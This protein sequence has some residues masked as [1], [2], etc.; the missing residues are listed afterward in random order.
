MASESAPFQSLESAEASSD[1]LVF[2]QPREQRPSVLEAFTFL[3]KAERWLLILVIGG[4]C[5]LLS[6]MVPIVP[7]MFFSGYIM[8]LI[9]Q[10]IRRPNATV[11]F[12]N[13][14]DV[15]AY[16]ERGAWTVLAQIVLGILISIPMTICLIGLIIITLAVGESGITQD[17]SAQMLLLTIFIFAFGCLLL[18]SLVAYMFAGILWFRSGMAGSFKEAFQFKWALS[19]IKTCGL[20]IFFGFFCLA[21]IG[22]LLNL[23]GLLMFLVGTYFMG[24]WSAIAGMHYLS[25]WYGYY[26]AQGGTPIPL[27]P[28]LRLEKLA[29]LNETAAD[30]STGRP[31]D[32]SG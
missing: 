18:I 11:L 16:L 27:S 5:Y 26:L 22:T 1:S 23:L 6:G 29:P 3:F 2:A 12:P 17:W 24:A 28:K 8:F 14:D 21:L 25:Q 32:T 19:F 10:Q 4:C 9:E 15:G 20:R 31:N 30:N 13:F 7:V